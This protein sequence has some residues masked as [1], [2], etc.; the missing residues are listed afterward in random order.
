[1]LEQGWLTEGVF[2]QVRRVLRRLTTLYSGLNQVAGTAT[3]QRRRYSGRLRLTSEAPETRYVITAV[4]LGKLK[5]ASQKMR[6][7]SKPCDALSTWQQAGTT[8][9]DCRND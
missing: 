4:R 1:M 2:Q 7:L 8:V 9:A 6:F 5:R 3:L